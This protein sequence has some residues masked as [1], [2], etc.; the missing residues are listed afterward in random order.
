MIY[1]YRFRGPQSVVLYMS[2]RT[3]S[4]PLQVGKACLMPTGDFRPLHPSFHQ[5]CLLPR[6][7]SCRHGPWPTLAPNPPFLAA[8]AAPLRP[9]TWLWCIP[10]GTFGLS[11]TGSFPHQHD[12]H[13]FCVHH[14]CVLFQVQ[15][16]CPAVAVIGTLWPLSYYGFWYWQQGHRGSGGRCRT[17]FLGE[18][19]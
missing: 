7:L 15:P 3:V 17:L 11:L 1:C 19:A 12:A 14:C 18:A 8:F 2:P 10:I 4:P 9:M 16:C 6:S 5:S 13:L